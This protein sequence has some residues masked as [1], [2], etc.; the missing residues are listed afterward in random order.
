MHCP[1][2]PSVNRRRGPVVESGNAV[3]ICNMRMS[4]TH[5]RPERVVVVRPRTRVR[6]S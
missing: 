1:V 6:G 3:F 5:L 4:G 2:K